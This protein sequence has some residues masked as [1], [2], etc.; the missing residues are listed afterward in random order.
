MTDLF[1]PNMITQTQTCI[2]GSSRMT[3]VIFDKSPLRQAQRISDPRG[4]TLITAPHEDDNPS[5]SAD[6]YPQRMTGTA[7]DVNLLV[8]AHY[9]IA[10][11]GV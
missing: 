5:T 11:T 10:A 2:F 1:K 8:I 9:P 6:H 4:A 7:L 3:I